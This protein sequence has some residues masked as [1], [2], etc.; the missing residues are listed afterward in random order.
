[1]ANYII[2]ACPKR[3][4]YVNEYLVP[5]MTEQG[6]KPDHIQVVCDTDKKGCLETTMQIFKNLPENGSTWH[7]QDDI[8]ISSKFKKETEKRRD[9]IVCGICTVYDHDPVV[10]VTDIDHIWYSFPCI[11]IPNSVAIECAKWFYNTVIHDNNKEHQANIKAKKFDDSFF[12]EY[13]ETYRRDIKI[14]NL[15]PNIVDHIDYLLGGSTINYGRA[16]DEVISMFWFEP[17]LTDALYEK[18]KKIYAS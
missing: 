7:L 9:G 18:L 11:C 2:H 17:D 15:Y 1:M 6:I 4:W 12:R 13:V 10:G 3:M 5:S 14:T 8:I 16:Q